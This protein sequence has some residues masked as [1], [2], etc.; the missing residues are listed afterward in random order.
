MK[1]WLAAYLL[2]TTLP[3]FSDESSHV[4]I[5]GLLLVSKEKK[6]Q[7]SSVHGIQIE[8][9]SIPGG[10]K[11]LKRIL[12]PLALGQ[13]LSPEL[14]SQIKRAIIQ[15]YRKHGR[16]VVTVTIPE[17]EIVDGV[18]EIV[19]IEAKLGKIVCKGN[20]WFSDSLIRDY[21]DIEPGDAISHDTLLTDVTWMNRNPFRRTDV[22][23]TPGETFGTT[24]IELITK[25]RFPLRLYAGGDNTGND[26]TGNERWFFG[27]N[28]ANAF[29]CDH[30]LTYQYTANSNF[31]DYVAHTVNY[32]APL[33][34]RHILIL[35]GGYSQVHPDLTF[36]HESLGIF[37]SHGH[38][39]QASL[40]YQMPWGKLYRRSLKEFVVGFDFKN[41][42][43]NLEFIGD[44]TI[45]II[46]KTVNITQFVAGF[47]WGKETKKHKFSFSSEVFISPGKMVPHQRVS[48]FEN[49]RPGAKPPYIYGKIALGDLY[50]I[51][52]NF[53]LSGL[54]R[55]QI[56]S[57]NL[58]PSEQYG[59]GGFNTVRGYNERILNVDDAFIGNIEIR[60]PTMHLRKKLRDELIL[61]AFMD[62]AV[63]RNHKEIEEEKENEFLWSVGP[64]L[65]YCINPYLSVRLDWGFQLH[66]IDFEDPHMSKFH[67]GFLL[68]Y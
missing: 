3:L 36:K 58:L 19:V 56:S 39:A 57:Q 42:N 53:T 20:R 27:F 5:K 33:P 66:K 6:Q 23:F 65:R 48:D 16:P 67:F 54:I 4:H 21:L 32:T 28:W 59:L 25:D 10:E 37:K 41:T 11:E 29:F 47:N 7:H 40:R 14:L 13:P 68:S 62:Y 22:L 9:L 38:S 60:F 43:N 49:L 44:S 46:T 12:A 64:G 1:K 45:P 30:Q 8:D 35:F 63:G 61:L 18:I 55:A 31:N 15:Y 52:W 17:Q 51:P 2:F 34:W 50:K 26:A 24:N